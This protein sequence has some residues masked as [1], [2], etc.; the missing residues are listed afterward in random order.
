[1]HTYCIALGHYLT[2]NVLN[3]VMVIIT[4]AALVGLR[5]IFPIWVDP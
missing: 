4:N 1:M 5:A 3:S 2:I